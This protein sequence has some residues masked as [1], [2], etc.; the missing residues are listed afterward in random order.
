MT[1][2][3]IE[4][5]NT[6]ERYV[7]FLDIMGFKDLV[8]RNKHEDVLHKITTFFDVVNKNRDMFINTLKDPSYYISD[9]D[10]KIVTFSDSILILSKN[11][12]VKALKFI[13]LYL[14]II[15]ESSIKLKIPIKGALSIGTITADFKN[16][17]FFGQPI[18]D[19][20]LLQDELKY[21]GIIINSS[22]E[23]N[24][25]TFNSSEKTLTKSL[26]FKTKTPLKSGSINY[27]NLNYYHDLK[28]KNLEMLYHS[29]DGSPRIYVDNTIDMFEK[30][31]IHKK[32]HPILLD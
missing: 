23:K 12:N 1:D 3:N 18:I 28:L 26:I 15:I 32:K 2:K 4:W 5:E 25:N 31:Q 27:Y 22:V 6:C 24:I 10:F 29:V 30:Y 11:S 20:Y 19:S 9:F 13:L 16:N 17:I 21:Y 14:S 8:A 7:C